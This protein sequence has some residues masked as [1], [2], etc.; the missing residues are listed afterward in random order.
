MKVVLLADYSLVRKALCALLSPI[1]DINV[2]ADVEDEAAAVSLFDE[3]NADIVLI[4][5]LNPAAGL[6][7]V[8][9]LHHSL[10]S[11][12]AVLVTHRGDEEF[13]GQAIRLGARGCVSKA[14]DPLVLEKALR[15]V[16]A[17]E[18]WIS[19]EAATRI[20]SQLLRRDSSDGDAEAGL[21]RRE[22]DVLA[23]VAEGYQNK[24]IAAR[25]CVSDHTVKTHLVSIYK[26]LKVGGRFA[27]AMYYFQVVDHKKLFAPETTQSDAPISTDAVSA[28]RSE[29]R[30]RPETTSQPVGRK[31]WPGEASASSRQVVA[32]ELD[33]A[34]LS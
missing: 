13:E 15:A 11:A 10:P 30:P 34:R 17:G 4:E 16:A 25:L 7:T 8:S 5:S 3:L 12:K 9:R 32:R 24:E 1:K 22:F 26:K 29:Q 23:L 6:E 31:R 21:T 27:A 14:S 33:R 28:T 18:L 2:V 20:I 19:H